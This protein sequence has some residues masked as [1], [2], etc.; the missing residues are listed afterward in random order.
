[1]GTCSHKATRLQAQVLISLLGPYKLTKLHNC[2]TWTEVLGQS[3]ANSLIIG[4]EGMRYQKL[5]SDVTVEAKTQRESR[6]GDIADSPMKSE[7][8]HTY[9]PQLLLWW[10]RGVLVTYSF[11][12]LS[13]AAPWSAPPFPSVSWWREFRLTLVLYQ[14]LWGDRTQ[15]MLHMTRNRGWTD[16]P[17][18]QTARSCMKPIE[19]EIFW[20]ML[21]DFHSGS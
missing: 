11:G 21:R 13:A 8:M 6:W 10:R 16:S 9:C 7:M 17:E 19:K 12:W 1:M 18:T 15:V 5:T 4:P 2:H 3:H 20:S 14:L